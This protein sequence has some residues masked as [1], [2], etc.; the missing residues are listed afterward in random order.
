MEKKI[1]LIDG[2]SILNRA[3]YGLPELTNAEGL[4][5]NAIYGFLNILF[6]TIEEEKP[7]YIGVT[8]D[9]KAPTARHKMYEGYKAN[10]HGMPDEL[11]VQMP[12]IKDILNTEIFEKMDSLF[13]K[14]VDSAIKKRIIT[15]VTKYINNNY[16]KQLLENI[17]F[18]IL[19]KDTIL[20]NSIKEQGERYLFTLENSRLFDVQ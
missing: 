2:H 10:R 4:H 20:T 13:D 5:T 17:D 3:F 8:F 19:V 6:K 14:D 16:L 9:L 12:I 15:D 18:K 11:A 1:V 7:D